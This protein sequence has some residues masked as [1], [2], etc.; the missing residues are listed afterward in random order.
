MKESPLKPLHA[1]AIDPQTGFVPAV[2]PLPRLPEAF[3]A[4]E[5]IIPRLSALIRSRRLRMALSELPVLDPIEL[6]APRER[7]RALLLLSVFAN[8][9]VWGGKEPNLRIPA[10]IAVPLCA[11]S[12]V[13]Q[14][15]PI[16]HYAS[17]AL[18]NWCRVDSRLSLSA[19]NS[20][21][22]VQFLGGVDED[23]FFTASIGVELAG[24]ALLPNLHGAVNCSHHD[25][26]EVLTTLLQLMIVSMHQ[27]LVALE[28]MR[29]WCLPYIF[30]HRVRVFLRGW[31]SPGAIYE[32]VSETPRQYVG[33][34]A[35]QSSLIQVMDALLGVQHSGEATGSYLRAM[36]RY[37]PIGHRQFLET[38]EQ[39]SRV[40]ERAEHGSPALRTAYNELVARVAEFRLH[41]IGLAYDY[42]AKPSG[43]TDSKKGTGDTDF[44]N[45]LR[46]SHAETEDTVIIAAQCGG[47]R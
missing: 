13:L 3:L 37:M 8:A 34:S 17:M 43:L 47:D 22:Q 4:W 11:V 6:V 27:L 44:A 46:N 32:G 35:A 39:N 20:R 15:P 18:N 31:P 5:D 29:E 24:A 36:R 14:R 19:D 21:M 1:Y 10:Q 9:W 40:R 2:D 45:F 7:E 41:H 30:Y 42:I 25:S 33:G 28:R 12:N 26:D 16:V 38:V 23:W